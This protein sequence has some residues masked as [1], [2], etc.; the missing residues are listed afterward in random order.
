MKWLKRSEAIYRLAGFLST[1]ESRDHEEMAD[2]ILDYLEAN[3]IMLPPYPPYI[4]DSVDER[5]W[6]LEDQKGTE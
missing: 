3:D 5:G 2:A 6:A 4:I 1:T